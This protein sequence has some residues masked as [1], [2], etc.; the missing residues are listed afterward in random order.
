MNEREIK[1]KIIRKLIRKYAQMRYVSAIVYRNGPRKDTFN[2]KYQN[3][4]Q[5]NSLITKVD[6]AK[7]ISMLFS[8]DEK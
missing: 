4:R 3:R 7:I 6:S 1:C 5:E 2:H 8:Y